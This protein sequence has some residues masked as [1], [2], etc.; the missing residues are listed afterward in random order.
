[1]L[2]YS[3]DICAT[4][5]ANKKSEQDVQIAKS[6][7]YLVASVLIVIALSLVGLF[8]GA[9]LKQQDIAR[10]QQEA[11]SLERIQNQQL[12]QQNLTDKKPSNKWF[13]FPH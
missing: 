7:L 10:L 3:I 6:V 4:A 8:V 12:S 2:L 11:A 1:M 13:I 9:E 5:M